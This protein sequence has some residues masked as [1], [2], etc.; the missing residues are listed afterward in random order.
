MSGPLLPVSSSFPPLPSSFFLPL[1]FPSSSFQ[2][3]SFLAL[4]PPSPAASSAPFR[5]FASLPFAAPPFLSP[6]ASALSPTSSSSPLFLFPFAFAPSLSSPVLSS[7]ARAPCW[8]PSPS[9]AFAAGPSR[10]SAAWAAP[11]SHCD[12]DFD[13]D[14][15][16]AASCACEQSRSHCLSC[17]CYLGLLRAEALV[18]LSQDP[19]HLKNPQLFPL[20]SFS[21]FSCHSLSHYRL[22]YFLFS[23]FFF[24]FVPFL[25]SLGRVVNPNTLRIHRH[26]YLSTEKV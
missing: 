21:S 7:A 20:L 10:D 16:H 25:L 2:R 4:F 8:S 3:A 22:N 5:A 23:C 6:V 1:P 17:C 26:P 19:H 18:P 24:S 11:D 14:C 15:E 9:R 12:S 13:C